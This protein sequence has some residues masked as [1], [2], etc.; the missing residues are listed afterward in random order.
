MF[1]RKKQNSDIFKNKGKCRTQGSNEKFYPDRDKNINPS[2]ARL[3]FP[4]TK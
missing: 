1:C 2:L 3:A 4:K